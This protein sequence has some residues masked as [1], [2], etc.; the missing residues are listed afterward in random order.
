M[1]ARFSCRYMNRSSTASPAGE[2][3]PGMRLPPVRRLAERLG[4]NHMTVAKAY[5][6]FSQEAMARFLARR[7]YPK[8]LERMKNVYAAKQRQLIG[9]LSAGMPPGTLIGRPE[10][11]LTFG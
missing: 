4:I 10:G 9:S 2:L 11:D 1:V 5:R 3:T 8:V 7:N 6:G